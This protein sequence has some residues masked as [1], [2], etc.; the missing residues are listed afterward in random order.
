[1]PIDFFAGFGA[2]KL[3][4]VGFPADNLTTTDRNEQAHLPICERDVLTP[5]LGLP[6]VPCRLGSA[7]QEQAHACHE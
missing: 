1:M 7:D 3:P 4:S 6:D 2:G 5:L